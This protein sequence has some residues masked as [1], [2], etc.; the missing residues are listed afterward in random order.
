MLVRVLM[1]F[2]LNSAHQKDIVEMCLGRQSKL[3]LFPGFDSKKKKNNN[4][5]S[6]VDCSLFCFF[7]CVKKLFR[8]TLNE[9]LHM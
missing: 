3:Y 8:K 1:L 5:V 4:A 9:S 7:I 6:E 2:L